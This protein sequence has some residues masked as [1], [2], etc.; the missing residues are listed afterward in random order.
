MLG[1]SPPGDVTSVD[2]DA[3]IVLSNAQNF[4]APVVTLGV[5]DEQPVYSGTSDLEATILPGAIHYEELD[6]EEVEVEV[7]QTNGVLQPILLALGVV[8]VIALIGIGVY[9]ARLSQ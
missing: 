6:A 4:T 5:V 1:S 7:R 8:I 2:L 9:Y 3:T